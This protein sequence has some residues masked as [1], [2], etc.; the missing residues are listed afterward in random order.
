MDFLVKAEILPNL[1]GNRVRIAE[2]SKKWV[3]KVM[4]KSKNKS[5]NEY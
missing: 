4:R 5:L 3:Q 1:W 2:M